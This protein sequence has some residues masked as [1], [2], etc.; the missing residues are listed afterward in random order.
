MA[1]PKPAKPLVRSR[2]SHPE[3]RMLYR[4]TCANF[5]NTFRSATILNLQHSATNLG[6]RELTVVDL[7]VSY[8][9]YTRGARNPKALYYTLEVLSLNPAPEPEAPNPETVSLADDGDRRKARLRHGDAILLTPGRRRN[10]SFG[11][12]R[13]P[14][15]YVL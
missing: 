11:C 8:R 14:G 7:S 13:L 15:R 5:P 6:F 2:L 3:V 4:E 12:C 9:A 10:G 1:V